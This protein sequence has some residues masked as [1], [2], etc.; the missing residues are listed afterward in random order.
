MPILWISN[1]NLYYS[2][3][4]LNFL[5]ELNYSRSLSSAVTKKGWLFKGPEGKDKDTI[6]SFTRVMTV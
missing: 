5:Q 1:I 6:I 2:N 4:N 3:V